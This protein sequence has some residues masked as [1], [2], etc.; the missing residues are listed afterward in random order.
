MNIRGHS[1]LFMFNKKHNGYVQFDYESGNHITSSEL[2]ERLKEESSRDSIDFDKYGIRYFRNTL[3]RLYGHYEPHN[4]IG[5]QAGLIVYHRSAL[6]K[7][8]FRQMGK[9]TS[10]R[11]IA[12]TVRVQ[13]KP[14]GHNG[15]ILTGDYEHAFKG[16]FHSNVS[17]DR[18]EFDASYKKSMS[19]MR[20]FSIRTGIGFYTHKGDEEYFL[21]YTN[22]HNNNIISDWHEEW[23]GEFEL[24]DPN[25]YNASDYYIRCNTSYES[26]LLLLSFAPWIGKFIEH[27]RFYLSALAVRNFYP[28]IECGYAFTNNIFSLGFF[29]SF[30]HRKYEGV[31][32]K[33]NIEL[34]EDW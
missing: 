26:P 7:E 28:Y 34:F 22:F 12:P 23:V 21:D 6:D 30:S 9:V 14:W 31:G 18:W 25:W 20:E 32:L 33:F 4:R 2:L 19:C 27:E 29:T 13:Y 15:P 5:L 16:I 11:T 10:Y 8:T 3:M 17:Y 24:L 1:W